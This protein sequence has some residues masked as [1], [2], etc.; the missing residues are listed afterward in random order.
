ML[1]KVLFPTQLIVTKELDRKAHMWLSSLS[2]HLEKQ[3]VREP[4]ERVEGLT[5]EIEKQLADAVLEVS[6]RANQQVVEELRGDEGMCQALLEIMEPEINRIVEK[7]TEKSRREVEQSKKEVE[8]SR[9]EVEGIR[10]EAKNEAERLRKEA[11]KETERLRREAKDE[12]VQTAKKMLKSGKFSVEETREC[13][14]R[15][16]VEEIEAIAKE[17]GQI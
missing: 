11:K 16:S 13:V 8:K 14:P 17:L 3:E 7:A 4:L 5:Q 1:D 9:R 6:I 15:L 12:A 2:N 10:K